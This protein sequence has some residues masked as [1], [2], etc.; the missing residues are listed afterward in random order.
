VLGGRDLV[1]VHANGRMLVSGP[2]RAEQLKALVQ[3]G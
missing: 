1:I 3:G 2:G